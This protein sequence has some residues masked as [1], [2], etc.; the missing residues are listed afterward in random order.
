ME[1]G[2]EAPAAAVR[3]VFEETGLS[4]GDPGPA[5]E[6][7]RFHF[8]FEGASYDQEETYF[9]VRTNAFEPSADRW[10]AN[11]LATTTGYRWWS[12]EELR[13]TNET[14]YPEGL[15]DFLEQLLGREGD[16]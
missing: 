1:P 15:A 5:V 4:V 9:L 16:Y 10:S 14:V 12:A 6:V 7:R 13:A 2:E 11:E 8:E 3:E